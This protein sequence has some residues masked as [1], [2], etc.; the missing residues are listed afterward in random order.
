MYILYNV[1]TD[2]I[3]GVSDVPFNPLCMSNND[4][5]VSFD[6]LLTC[7]RNTGFYKRFSFL[8]SQF[9]FIEGGD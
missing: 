4:L 7:D 9:G 1:F 6:Y 5:C 8:L 3:E 2:S